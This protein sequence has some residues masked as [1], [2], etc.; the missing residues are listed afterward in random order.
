MPT[1][2]F[3]TMNS[4]ALNSLPSDLRD[5]LP[6]KQLIRLA[7][8]AVQAADFH[9]AGDTL[10]SVATSQEPMLMTVLAYCYASGVFGSREIE[11]LARSDDA[12]CYLCA[13]RALDWNCLRQFRRQHTR[14]LTCCLTSLLESAWRWKLGQSSEAYF[15]TRLA[16]YIDNSLG[17]WTQP[18]PKLDF[19]QAA[20]RRVRGAAR[21]DSMEMD[22]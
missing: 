4:L 6:E 17:R 3:E 19:L 12:V 20:Q 13:R 21:A 22:D 5:W 2:A 14:Q 16:H 8:E 11:Q 9:N 18:D 1:I 10:S 7:L 15:P